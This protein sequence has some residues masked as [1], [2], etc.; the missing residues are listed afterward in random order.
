MPRLYVVK[1]KSVVLEIKNCSSIKKIESSP[2]TLRE[3][4]SVF[5]NC[6]EIKMSDRRKHSGEK[7][8]GVE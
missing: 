1:E 8:D 5:L 4:F 2:L 6:L 3:F 7:V